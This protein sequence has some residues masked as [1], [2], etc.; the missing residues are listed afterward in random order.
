MLTVLWDKYYYHFVFE[1]SKAQKNNLPNVSYLVRGWQC[2]PR[3]SVSPVVALAQTY[4]LIKDKRANIY[5]DSTYIWGL[6]NDFKML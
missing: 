3:P 2:H 4:Q 5:T 1:E 6:V